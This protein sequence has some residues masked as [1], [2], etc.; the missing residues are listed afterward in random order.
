M[1][2]SIF[3]SVIGMFLLVFASACSSEE[4]SKNDV[5]TA[6]HT[7]VMAVSPSSPSPS[8]IPSSKVRAAGES[9]YGQLEVRSVV[10]ENVEQLGAHSC[11]G[12]EEDY[13][14]SGVYK[15]QFI[16]TANTITELALPP[17]AGFIQPRDETLQL[18]KLAFP[19]HDVFVITP[20][21]TDCHGISFYL[22]DVSKDG[23]F[24]LQFVTREGTFDHFDFMPN[25][26]LKVENG[27]L[28]V[29]HGG[30]AGNESVS[31]LQFKPDFSKHVLEL[32]PQSKNFPSSQN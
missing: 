19:E 22:I 18:K 4:Q 11:E 26:E 10:P 30:S 23:A 3:L 8:P 20:N 14:I 25:T 1:S 28:V 16:D 5:S 24:P 7:A 13:R 27:V 29:Q 9:Q 17:L 2:R 32:Q 31:P 15:V 12:T 6:P 21:Y